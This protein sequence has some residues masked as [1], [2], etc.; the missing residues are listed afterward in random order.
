MRRAIA[1][2]SS[3]SL[4]TRAMASPSSRSRMACTWGRIRRP[5]AP[6]C[7]SA[8]RA[9]PARPADQVAEDRGVVEKSA[10]AAPSSAW[11]RSSTPRPSEAAVRTTL[12]PASRSRSSRTA[13]GLARSTLLKTTTAGIWRARTP[14]GSCPRSRPTRPASATS[15]P[16]SVRSKTCR[17]RATRSSP[18]A[19]ASS[20]PAVSMNSTGPSGSSS[21]GFSTGSVVVPARSET[22]DTSCRVI[23]FS[24]DDL[25]TLR[26][27]N[28]PM[29]RRKPLGAPIML[30][31]CRLC[32][33]GGLA[34]RGGRPPRR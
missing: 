8:R 3:R 9:R 12:Q 5:A 30:M 22:I 26:R 19:P 20:M 14:R 23:A 29:C 31:R 24:R 10:G 11:R 28:R 34:Y 7:R 18:R 1:S 2:C 33:R 25:P 4:T 13:G 17:V 32:V 21:I 16:R 15:T 6:P 27:P